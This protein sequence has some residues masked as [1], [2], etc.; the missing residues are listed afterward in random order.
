MYSAQGAA[1]ERPLRVCGRDSWFRSFVNTVNTSS[2]LATSYTACPFPHHKFIRNAVRV[3]SL[4]SKT[5]FL[6]PS[7]PFANMC[8]LRLYTPFRV[9]IRRSCRRHTSWRPDRIVIS[10]TS[11]VWG[12]C[13]K[14][15]DGGCFKNFFYYVYISFY[16]FRK[17]KSTL[18][19][20][21]N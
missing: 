14:F 20:D 15:F 19:Y 16:N 13:K 6:F 1:S 21:F 17:K 4:F 18:Y 3:R 11:F 12:L 5:R 7:K 10:S 8:R 9:S 2:A